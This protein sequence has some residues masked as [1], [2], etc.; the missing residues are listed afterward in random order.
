MYLKSWRKELQKA[1]L[2]LADTVMK[3]DDQIQ[4]EEVAFMNAYLDEIGEDRSFAESNDIGEADA[5]EIFLK[6]GQKECRKAYLELYALALCNEEYAEEE[7]RYMDDLAGIW[8]IPGDICAALQK[9][10]E[11]MNQ[12]YSE[13]DGILDS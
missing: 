11:V 9:K 6:E 4:E 2:I 10:V 7:R 5:K 8:D 12:I 3:V 13:L 1:F